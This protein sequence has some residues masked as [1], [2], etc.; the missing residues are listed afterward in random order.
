MEAFAED[1]RDPVR[2]LLHD[3]HR[4]VDGLEVE[5][6]ELLAGPDPREDQRLQPGVVAD[7]EEDELGE[8]GA[9]VIPLRIDE[10][11]PVFPGGG[12]WGGNGPMLRLNDGQEK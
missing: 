3:V 10:S 2:D 6:A 5:R 11:T 12:V 4:E 1:V 7:V 8:L 9:P